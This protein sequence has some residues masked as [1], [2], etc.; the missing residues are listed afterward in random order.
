M[1]AAEVP[2]Q[3]RGVGALENAIYPV[4]LMSAQHFTILN[5]NIPKSLSAF[6]RAAATTGLTDNTP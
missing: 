4:L 1:S 5:E 3:H 2:E 6:E